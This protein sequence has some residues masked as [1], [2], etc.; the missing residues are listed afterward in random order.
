MRFF[1]F[2]KGRLALLPLA[3]VCFFASPAAY[4]QQKSADNTVL[5]I[6]K[7]KIDNTPTLISFA[8]GAKVSASQPNVVFQKYLGMTGSEH[9]MV[10]KNTT[11]TKNK[12]TTDRYSQYY[13]GIKVEYGGY[14]LTSKDGAVAFMTG[15]YYDIKGNLNDKPVLTESQAFTKALAIVGAEKYMWEDP[16]SK[17][18]LQL[19]YPGKDTTYL[20]K[21]RLVWIEDYKRETPDRKLKL[22]YC[23]D[24]YAQKPLSRQEVFVDATTGAMLFSNSLIKHTAATG[25]S[26][27]SGAVP[28]NTTFFG[29]SYLLFDSVRGNGVYTLN[30]QSDTIIT[31]AVDFAS[32]TNS[33]PPTTADSQA[34]DAH[35]GSE[36]VYDYWKTQQG[37]LSWDGLDGML[38][39]Y[40]H[41]TDI[42]TH[43]GPLDNAFWDGAEM[44]YGDG[45]GSGTGGFD[46]VVALDVVGHEIGHGICQ[47]TAALIYAGESGALNE[48]FSD[49]WGATIEAWAN[50]HE[51]DA[52]S[53]STWSI[54]EEIRAGSPLRRMDFPHLAG[55]PDTYNGTNWFN[56]VSCTPTSGPTGN[57]HCGVHTNSSVLN[58]WYY[59]VVNGGAGTN[60]LSNTYVVNSIGFVPAA[61][62]LYQTEL[63]LPS[64]ADYSITAAASLSVASMLY[65][66]C[67]REY[68]SVA[69]AWYA[70]GVTA[71]FTPC[72]AQIGFSHSLYHVDENA[73][74]TSCPSSVTYL[75]GVKPL[76]A[77]FTGGNPVVG[78]VAAAGTTAVAGVDYT[79]S[80]GTT[81]FLVGDT[82][83]HF[84]TLT[85]FDNGAVHDSKVIN[86]AVTLTAAGSTAIISPT[87]GT[88]TLSIY[89][90]DSIPT[91]GYTQLDNLNTSGTLV[92]TS[93]SSPFVGTDNLGHTQYLLSAAEMT[94]AGVVPFVPIT[95]I[96]FTI[97]TKNSTGAFN[98]YT[99]KMGNTSATSLSSGFIGGLTQ[100]YNGNH[101]TN[102]GL[103]T[104][105]FNSGTF[106][107]DG[108][109]NV[110]V[111][112]CFTNSSAIAS[113]EDIVRGRNL[114][115]IN[116]CAYA[117]SSAAGTGCSLIASFLS[118]DRPEIRFKQ[119]ESPSA[120]ESTLSA[121]RTWDVHTGQEVYFYSFP[122]DTSVIAGV[123]NQTNNL[124]CVNATLTGAGTGFATASFSPINRSLKEVTITPT[125][126]GA[127]T[128]ADV[129]IYL[130]NSELASVAPGT[131]S[132]IRTT[133]PTDATV[134]SGNSVV[135]APT[136]LTG[137]NY[138]GFRGSFTGFGRYFLIDG[139]LSSCANPAPITG[140]ASVCAGS[141]ITL[142]DITS[143]GNWAS[144]STSMATVGS[145]NGVLTAL[146]TGDVEIDYVVTG[147]CL[148][149]TTI[150]INPTP[151]TITGGN[152]VCSGL[153]TTLSDGLSGGTW[154]S[155]LTG[156][157]TIGSLNGGVFGVSPGTTVIRY[158]M[159][160]TGCQTVTTVTVNTSPSAITGAANVCAGSTATLSD[161]NAGG[162]WTSSNT[163]NATIGTSNGIVS[164]LVAGV[165]TI[166]YTLGNCNTTRLLTVFASPGAI[167]GNTSVC[168]GFTTTLSDGGP[169][170]WTSSNTTVAT[171][172]GGTGIASGLTA[173][174]STISFAFGN[175]CFATRTLTV[176]ASPG[177]I[178]GIFSVCTGVSATLSDGIS[179]GTWA[180][181]NTTNAS[182]GSSSGI[183]SGLLAGT[184]NISYTM[185]GN[186]M[187]THTITV[188]TSPVPIIGNT[189][190]CVGATSTLSDAGGGTWSSSNTT[191]A[192]IG[193][194]N[195][196]TF[197]VLAGAATIS[198]KFASGCFAT[199]SV[200]INP[201]PAA[202][203]G[204]TVVCTGLTVS[205]SNTVAGGNWASS[206]GNASVGSSSGVVTGNSAGPSTI[207]YTLTGG[208]FVIKA[209]TVNASP[210]TITGN[211]SICVGLTS[212]LSDAGGGTW[213]SSNTANAT[214]GTGNGVVLGVLS[215]T[216]NIT[217]KLASG[218][219][220]SKSV[221][222]NPIPT[223]L[224]GTA[225]VCVGSQ[226]SL[227]DGIGGG[228]WT[229]SN[230]TVATVDPTT[231]LIDGL[232]NGNTTINYA[233]G[234]GCSVN[235]IVTVNPTPG[236]IT[237]PSN[238]CEGAIAT[239]S[240]LSAGGRWTSSST[241]TATVGSL[242]GAVSG[243]L[244]GNSTITYAFLSGCNVTTTIQ[245]N[246][247]PT[248]I[249]GVASV[250][251]GLATSLS[252]G[253]AGGGWSS[254]NALVATVDAI[255]GVVDG[256]T[257]GMVP[258]TY[259]LGAGCMAV[260]TVT[261]NLTPAAITGAPN[262][263]IGYT[264][265]LN[266]TDPGGLWSSS[267]TDAAIGT[268]GDA[269]GINP[270]MT[271][272]SYT[273][274]TGCLATTALSVNP[275]PSAVMGAP[276]FCS[277][278]STTLTNTVGGGAWITSDPAVATIDAV[279]GSASGV[280]PGTATITYS[281]GGGCESVLTVTVI[282]TPLPISGPA[283][284][285][286][287]TTITL[288]D[289]TPGGSWISGSGGLATISSGGVLSG[290]ALGNAPIT[291]SLGTGCE[292]STT[293][294]VNA[295]NVA[296][297]TGSGSGCTGQITGLG[298]LTA[299][300]TWSSSNPAL[301][302]VGSTGNVNCLSTGAVIISYS[303]TNVCGTAVATHILAINPTPFIGAISGTV[304]LCIGGSG[305]L[306][307]AIPGGVW[308]SGNTSVATVVPGTASAGLISGMAAGTTGVYYAVT[309][310]A[311]CIATTSATATV[312]APPVVS[313]TAAGPT[314]LCMGG[315]VVLNAPTSAGYTYQWQLNGVS[316]S[317]ATGATFTASA[318][319]SY[320]VFI[321][322]GIGCIYSSTPVVVSVGTTSVV[323]PSVSI[324]ATPDTTLCMVA[325]T[326][327]FTAL[328]VNGGSSPAIQ[329]YVNSIPV[330][331]GLTYAYTPAAGDVV[332]CILTS[333][334]P[335]ASPLTAS[336]TV[337]M[338]IVPAVTPAVAI[339][340]SPGDTL[341]S[342][343][344]ATFNALP[345]F[346]GIAPVY[347]WTV[348]GLAAGTGSSYSYSPG[349]GDVVRCNMNSNYS[350]VTTASVISAPTTMHITSPTVNLLSIS[351][352]KL[353]LATMEIDTFTATTSNP[354]SAPTFQWYVNGIP[355]AGA[356]SSKFITSSLTTGQAVTCKYTSSDLCTMP[357][358][359]T[360]NAISVV[361]RVSTDMVGRSGNVT[362][363]PNPNN[364]TFTIKGQ[365]SGNNETAS[366]VVTDMLGQVVYN[367]TL[368]VNN[369]Q[370]DEQ[371]TLSKSVAAG[372]YLVKLTS[373]DDHLVFHIV[374]DK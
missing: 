296:A 142:S 152:T 276:V 40:V 345:V 145:G 357:R 351:L 242:S 279:T 324:S 45:S 294:F 186:C 217:Y 341:C 93:F 153:S 33:W 112:M 136:L 218:C 299:G 278:Q 65:G 338:D 270:G 286:A 320:T 232:S 169:G 98:G 90:N 23:F 54:G 349:D 48:G 39:G 67:S 126:N 138:V 101:T 131:L 283:T 64:T 18:R 46:P 277:S 312:I 124:G 55:D 372:M 120:V 87:A 63:T 336:A 233:L 359:I 335:C 182:I 175:G 348:N 109:S 369:G 180:S 161:A 8:P 264:T 307:D 213:S 84:A 321:N 123:K 235:K 249:A 231:G 16:K 38:V 100:V 89:N 360:S 156:I 368:P 96:G 73:H 76:G 22:A 105:V 148:A 287:G 30:A 205:L 207:S 168:T 326:V 219:L 302:T 194:L 199:T 238:V 197:G 214:V 362:L 263:C 31:T 288:A 27:Y 130:R 254:G 308:S 315:S 28:I 234:A 358:T 337:T 82:T 310:G 269:L 7:N 92:S 97:L 71:A 304:S 343:G 107:W 12:I 240:D 174:T 305:T 137:T 94:A 51:T 113:A 261:V 53:K 68:E 248:A 59:L 211:T 74:S 196:A 319:G 293:I 229:S 189:N 309:S 178:L 317:G 114:S 353:V 176:N 81:T 122:G 346:G 347:H 203:T 225:A 198:Y 327:T 49:C 144:T 108:V 29:G 4:G 115:P 271:T 344:T 17:K 236:A 306:S 297:I 374:I 289:A 352:T 60:D 77:A 361:I 135:V 167:T 160:A 42:D 19:L 266:D 262:V 50:P 303:T 69:N 314:S 364:G 298:D 332:K 204:T 143:G 201:I 9:A 80:S 268:A 318:S 75:I 15:N 85:V 290:I 209:V 139:P 34:L 366:L 206:N 170:N 125:T 37:R 163:T 132:L 184:S 356:N 151:P 20:P 342:A 117:N 241:S 265:T 284:L 24:I 246:P 172:A 230:T 331:T 185:T 333:S 62:I 208:C 192:T 323:V 2:Q 140:P 78:V 133:A 149:S 10:L 127:T 273:F 228:I 223:A 66:P 216:A 371:V 57:D 14:T 339:S 258:I 177:P 159:I 158:K 155:S 195:G 275:L 253:V 355:V 202:I 251:T 215:G 52:V 86:L 134:N 5:S 334:A 328:P 147:G 281:L 103:D 316:I 165:P 6:Q 212:T 237:G 119:V 121:S 363:V 272:I 72:V 187:V 354:G 25:H 104:L 13:K 118:F 280:A 193:S 340:A 146:T 91:L 301:A 191:I 61:A 47:A 330:G 245:V 171:I 257:P 210:G 188:N 350:C 141:T 226:T 1:T 224:T 129:T 200:Q 222:V 41:M 111:E 183:V 291:Y 157:A 35:W 227:S 285:C 3:I 311:G 102:A 58:K 44:C 282:T 181:S 313:I 255:T 95:E 179:G 11:T 43:G 329:W 244:T 70:V 260:R 256:L 221:Q 36:M 166:T 325:T 83:T 274:P 365:L 56:V 243:V 110:A 21:G 190:I 150:H 99:V 267:T 173:G 373:G 367:N 88:A 259:D 292:A 322:N 162:I 250:C 106:M 116:V 164:G 300:G 220:T 26:K 128:T 79:L 239:L 252:N 154:S 247:S 32:A 370:I 295:P